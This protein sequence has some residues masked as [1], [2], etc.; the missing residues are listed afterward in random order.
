MNDVLTAPSIDYLALLPMIIVAG[1]AII[2]VLV[3]AFIPRGARRGIQLTIVFAA[4][5]AAFVILVSNA[6]IR[7]ITGSLAIDVDANRVTVND[8]DVDLTP[9]EFQL[10]I[11]LLERRGRTQSRR[12]L[13]ETV[14]DTTAEIETRTI[15]MHVGRLRA[16]LG[17][18]G[19]MIETVRGF[20][21][22]FRAED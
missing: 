5:I 4:L 11:C 7:V 16:K 19:D 2:G 15:D 14:W 3:E 12:G 10:L 20:G 17:P 8:A 13:L 18:A 22:R 9:K 21:Y 1:A 6:S